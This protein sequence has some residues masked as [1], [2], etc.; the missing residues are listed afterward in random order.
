MRAAAL[1]LAIV[2]AMLLPPVAAAQ[3]ADTWLLVVVG[4]G[5]DDEHRARFATLAGE[6]TAAAID[7]HG[8]A[9]A[10]IT[11]LV[12]RVELAA[13]IADGRS[14]RAEIEAS[15]AEIGS[16]AAAGDRVLVL[17]IGHGSSRGEETFFN[18]P[19]P[20]M[21]AADFAALLALLAEQEVG[22][23]NTASASG[24]FLAPLAAPGRTVVTATRSSRE[25]QEPVFVEHFVAAFTGEGADI[26]K[27]GRVSLLEAFV[28]ADAE[29]ARH[30]D[31]QGL[32]RT[33]HAR[34]ADDGATEGVAATEVADAPVAR[35][36]ALGVPAAA[37]AGAGSPQELNPEAR[38]LLAERAELEAALETLRASRETMAEIEYEDRLEELLVRIAEID[39]ELREQGGG[40]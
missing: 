27:D 15:V 32:I 4:V 12:E 16:R 9:P 11:T 2:I 10:N 23:V 38:A 31:S 3:L 37:A 25:S 8:I 13:E 1:A 22:L 35:R 20:D 24:G 36:F 34:L 19:G 28:Y 5:G 21:S 7:R 17:L 40:S 30:Y 33:E 29:V 14:T 26:D 6:M 39:R 18:L